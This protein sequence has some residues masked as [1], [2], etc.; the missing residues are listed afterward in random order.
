MLACS[1]DGFHSQDLAQYISMMPMSTMAR[2][3]A[4][5]VTYPNAYLPGPSDSFPGLLAITTGNNVTTTGVYYG[6]PLLFLYEAYCACFVCSPAVHTAVKL[7]QVL[8]SATE[9]TFTQQLRRCC[10]CR[11]KSSGSAAYMT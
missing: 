8:L 2:L 7:L 1:L 10:F 5:G 4:S 6:A 9:H 11:Q 3:A